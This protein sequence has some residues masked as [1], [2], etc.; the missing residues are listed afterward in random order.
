VLDKLFLPYFFFIACQP[1]RYSIPLPS[2]PKPVGTRVYSVQDTSRRDKI[3][4]NLPRTLVIQAWY[5]TASSSKGER[6]SYLPTGFLA[7]AQTRGYVDQK[8]DQLLGWR[9]IQTSAILGAPVS[10][11]EKRWPLL[12]FSPGVGVS[13]ASYTGLCQEMAS[14]GYVVVG[15]DHPYCGFMVLPNGKSNSFEDDPR[16]D[17]VD[18]VEQIAL[19]QKFVA[20]W[21]AGKPE[22]RIDSGH[23]VAFGHSIGGAG[24]LESGRAFPGFFRAV[25]DLDGDVW[26]DVETKGTLT[27]FLVL[28]NEPSPPVVIPDKMRQERDDE[29]N[30]VLAASGGR[31][32][33]VKIHG[34]FHLSFTDLPF[35]NPPDYSLKS[36]ADLD[37]SRGLMVIADLLDG[38]FRASFKPE[39]PR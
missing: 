1:A 4:K 23:M 9:D 27:K 8:A 30:T 32:T 29:W 16:R 17:P 39:S 37:P 24:A 6:A 18:K 12:V 28:L 25:A 11:A 21:L 26:G 31:G 20:R 13:R 36:G 15:I 35:L 2:G 5:P 33:L 19:D 10:R 22:L 7:A 38:F 34:T 14:R 3:D